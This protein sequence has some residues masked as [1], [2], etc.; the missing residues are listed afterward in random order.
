[1]MRFLILNVAGHMADQRLAN[2][3]YSA[4][5]LPIKIIESGKRLLNPSGGF[6]FDFPSQVLD[7]FGIP[8]QE[9]VDVILD[10]SDLIQN[11]TTV[12]DNAAD[13]LMKAGLD[14]RGDHGTPAF[15]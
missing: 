6:R 2:R 4:P 3:E 13:V 5:G 12:T 7:G 15:G 10:A 14:L 11:A 9:Q 1:M 8:S